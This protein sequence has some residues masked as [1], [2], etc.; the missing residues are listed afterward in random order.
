[1]NKSA[2]I[3]VRTVAFLIL[4]VITISLFG[5]FSVW[6]FSELDPA[7]QEAIGA[8]NTPWIAARREQPFV[9]SEQMTAVGHKTPAGR[10]VTNSVA[11]HALSAPNT[12]P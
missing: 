2:K 5:L 11:T 6:A 7:Q 1:M 8:I 3:I 4:T 12:D 9:P 10:P